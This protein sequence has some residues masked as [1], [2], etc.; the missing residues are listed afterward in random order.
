MKTIVSECLIYRVA[1]TRFSILD[2]VRCG[3]IFL[4]DNL[5]SGKKEKSQNRHLRQ[6]IPIP[7][8]QAHIVFGLTRR[9]RRATHDGPVSPMVNA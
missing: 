4:Y 3:E 5:N 9:W 1:I 6:E 8:Q 7:R 2:I